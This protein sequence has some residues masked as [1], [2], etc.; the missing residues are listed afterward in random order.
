MNIAMTP[1][2]KG[3]LGELRKKP[4]SMRR[5]APPKRDGEN[6]AAI[7]P[8]TPQLVRQLQSNVHS[9]VQPKEC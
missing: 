8:E 6:M 4:G 3:A 7:V 9:Y 5:V 1:S 2:L